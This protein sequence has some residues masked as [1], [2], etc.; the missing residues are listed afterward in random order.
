MKSWP[1]ILLILLTC[2]TAFELSDYEKIDVETSI[3]DSEEP[4][5]TIYEDK[6][7]VVYGIVDPHWDV[8]TSIYDIE[9]LELVKKVRL[10]N[11]PADNQFYPDITCWNDKCGVIY[12]NQ[13]AGSIWLQVWDKDFNERLEMYRIADLPPA[14][15]DPSIMSL[16]NGIGYVSYAYASSYRSNMVT[17]EKWDL[18]EGVCIKQVNY[19]KNPGN[20]LLFTDLAWMGDNVLLC[21]NNY[22]TPLGECVLYTK[23]LEIVSD[24][25]M[26]DD[27]KYH[28]S[29]S[30]V[31]C[32]GRDFFSSDYEGKG[33]SVFTCNGFLECDSFGLDLPHTLYEYRRGNV[34]ECYDNVLYSTFWTINYSNPGDEDVYLLVKEV[35]ESVVELSLE[36]LWDYVKILEY[37][38]NVL[39]G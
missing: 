6:I 19:T 3:L 34:I 22:P 21:Y 14:L 29:L 8:Y 36:Y 16:E 31:E 2:S 20:T 9:S 37:R 5:L 24:E 17:L 30:Y 11:D 39:E 23:D 25:L 38:I 7:Y 26:P 15:T 28:T 18:D 1:V 12:D 35:E 32:G 13:T 33:I 10:T 4:Q 27:N